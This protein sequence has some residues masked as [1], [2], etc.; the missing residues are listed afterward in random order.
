MTAETLIPDPNQYH[1]YNSSHAQ[2]MPLSHY[3]PLSA[4]L[5]GMKKHLYHMS[6]LNVTSFSTHVRKCVMG[7][8]PV[9]NIYVLII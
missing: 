1:T 6:W 9:L 3:F 2:V 4:V 7:A 5:Y 8:L